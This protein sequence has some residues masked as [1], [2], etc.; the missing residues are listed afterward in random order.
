ME[1]CTCVLDDFGCENWCVVDYMA[2]REKE[3]Y[4]SSQ[5]KKED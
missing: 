2:K 4:D 5:N 1:L 3:E